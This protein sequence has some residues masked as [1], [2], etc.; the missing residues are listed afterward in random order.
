MSKL[1]K[2]FSAVILLLCTLSGCVS[3]ITTDQKPFIDVKLVGVWTGEF[4]EEGGV[5][6]RWTQTRNADGSYTIDFS[7]TD[8]KG[9]STYFTESGR[10]WIEKGLFHEISLPDMKIPDKYQYAF[11]QKDCVRFD[12]IESDGLAE[13][14]GSYVFSEC[15]IADSPP[16]VINNTI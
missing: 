7:F 8:A 11:K 5:L 3:Q 4:L 16:A 10:W 9:E 13:E 6:K 1:V 15:L 14:P 12:L 2:R